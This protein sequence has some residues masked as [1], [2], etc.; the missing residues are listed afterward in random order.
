MIKY[1]KKDKISVEL[2]K[3][4]LIKNFSLNKKYSKLIGLKIYRLILILRLFNVIF[5]LQDL[6]KKIK[7]NLRYKMDYILFGFDNIIFGIKFLLKYYVNKKI[8]FF[9]RPLKNLIKIIKLKKNKFFKK[10]IVYLSNNKKV[11]KNNVRKYFDIGIKLDINKTKQKRIVSIKFIKF[12]KRLQNEK[13]IINVSLLKKKK[14]KLS[15]KQIKFF[16]KLILQQKSIRSNIKNNKINLLKLYQYIG[17]R[18]GFVFKKKIKNNIFYNFKINNH[19]KKI[20]SRLFFNKYYF[21]RK[22]FLIRRYDLGLKKYNFVSF[23]KTWFKNKHVFNLR[24]LKIFLK[25]RKKKFKFFLNK[26]RKLKTRYKKTKTAIL[27]FRSYDSNYYIT[28]TDLS[29]KVIYS[30]SAGM[31]STSN[32]KKTKT[33]TVVCIPMFFKLLTILK[34]YGIKNLKFELKSGMDKYFRSAFDFFVKKQMQVKTISLVSR[35]PHHLGQ[36]TNKPRRV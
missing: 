5:P 34:A 8:F 20:V 29:Y 3:L 35:D 6:K 33:S 2:K 17:Q 28:L 15:E 19:L 22:L 13:S 11:L 16:K 10:Y 7:S 24:K 26:L 32:N 27:H 30:C 31:V 25:K 4:N 14:K 12:L 18:K 21:N 9:L 36:R 1:I 23:L